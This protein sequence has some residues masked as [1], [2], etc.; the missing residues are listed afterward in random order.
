MTVQKSC[1]TL[2]WDTIGWDNI[3]PDVQILGIDL[4]PVGEKINRKTRDTELSV[5]FAW[6]AAYPP[7]MQMSQWT[8]IYVYKGWTLHVGRHAMDNWWG[9]WHNNPRINVYVVHVIVYTFAKLQYH[10]QYTKNNIPGKTLLR[11]WFEYWRHFEHK[12]NLSTHIIFW[13][14]SRRLQKALS[15]RTSE[16]GHLNHPNLAALKQFCISTAHNPEKNSVNWTWSLITQQPI[17]VKLCL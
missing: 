4:S 11:T 10:F 8:L 2:G 7:G 9:R 1:L 6:L 17:P 3:S 5:S 16:D 14:F 15:L 13:V 12:S